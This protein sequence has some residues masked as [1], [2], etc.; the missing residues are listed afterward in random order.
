MTWGLSAPGCLDK[1]PSIPG[2]RV[3]HR[4]TVSTAGPRPG[5]M[6]KESTANPPVDSGR[7][8]G[9]GGSMPRMGGSMPRDGRQAP[10]RPSWARDEITFFF[11]KS[12]ENWAVPTHG[13]PP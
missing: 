13:P 2:A 8:G 10:G 11:T 3:Y 7:G 9:M 4:Q 12:A 5:T 6:G 1:A